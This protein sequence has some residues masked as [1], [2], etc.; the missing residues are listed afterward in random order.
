MSTEKKAQGVRPRPWVGRVVRLAGRELGSRPAEVHNLG[1]RRARP[2]H[3]CLALRLRNVGAVRSVTRAIRSQ[4]KGQP[5]LHSFR[6]RPAQPF[7]EARA[8]AE[9]ASRTRSPR[10]RRRCRPRRCGDLSEAS[11][12]KHPVAACPLTASRYGWGRR[13]RRYLPSP[14]RGSADLACGWSLVGHAP[15]PSVSR[16]VTT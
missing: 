4:I 1:C 9:S 16:W 6:R 13:P 11:V 12:T 2:Q 5:H 15:A 8:A 3:G 10:H 14:G 7:T